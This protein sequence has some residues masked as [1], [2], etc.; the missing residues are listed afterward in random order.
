MV[1]TV[2]GTGS[3]SDG[4]HSLLKMMRIQA[5]MALNLWV[6]LRA[7]TRVWLGL[8]RKTRWE[9][10]R[11]WSDGTVLELLCDAGMYRLVRHRLHGR[12]G[13]SVS[14]EIHLVGVTKEAY[15]PVATEPVREG[16]HDSSTADS[17]P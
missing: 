7:A 11:Q 8:S 2:A 10:G 6:L 14:V 5:K 4:V 12:G 1:A 17:S 16:P 9:V 3:L 15:S 13:I